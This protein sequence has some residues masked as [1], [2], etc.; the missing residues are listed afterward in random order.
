VDAVGVNQEMIRKC[1]QWQ[2]K[3][4]RREESQPGLGLE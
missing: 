1:V 4:E 3:R 2:E